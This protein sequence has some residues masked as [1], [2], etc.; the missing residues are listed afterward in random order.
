MQSVRELI[1]LDM[2]AKESIVGLHGGNM[3]MISQ[4]TDAS[5][6]PKGKQS[7]LPAVHLAGLSCV[8]RW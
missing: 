6:A 3:K 7:S 5:R 1:P 2:T 4:K 8:W